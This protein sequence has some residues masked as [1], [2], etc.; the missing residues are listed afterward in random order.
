MESDKPMKMQLF[1]QK[2]GQVMEQLLG[3]VVGLA[4]LAIGLIVVFLIYSNLAANTT[5][6]ADGNAA[7]AVNTLRDATNTVPSW[8]SIIV[9]VIIGAILIGLVTFFRRGTR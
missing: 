7:A 8:L 9:L 6:A 2:K 3:I 1:K 5:V 4:A